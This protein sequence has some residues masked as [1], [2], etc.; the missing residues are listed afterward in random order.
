MKNRFIDIY[1]VD[2]TDEK[3]YNLVIDTDTQS[4]N[5]IVKSIIDHLEIESNQI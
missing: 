1:G 2:F 4:P 3:N 5:E